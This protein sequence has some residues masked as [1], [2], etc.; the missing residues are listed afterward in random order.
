MLPGE[1]S[2]RYLLLLLLLTLFWL[3]LTARAT[4]T[5]T[6]Q[7]FWYDNS[8]VFDL[9]VKALNDRFRM[10]GLQRPGPDGKT[11]RPDGL[12]MAISREWEVV[13]EEDID[14]EDAAGRCA[15]LL[16]LRRVA[17]T[18]PLPLDESGSSSS[19]SSGSSGEDGSSSSRSESASA[20]SDGPREILVANVHL[21]F[22][23][24]DAS[25]RIRVREVH[26]LLTHLDQ[27]KSTLAQAP[28]ALI[29]GDFNG[30][31][32]S[33]VVKFLKRY[34]WQCTYSLHNAQK[35]DGDHGALWQNGD[36]AA[37]AGGGGGGGAEEVNAEEEARWISHFTHQKRTVGVDYIWMLN[38]SHPR[39]PVPDWTDFVFSEM[40][41][42]LARCGF[43]RPADA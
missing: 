39:A 33:R 35:A 25:G 43:S 12:F 26:K 32:G 9:Y 14:F 4:T 19:S 41:Q 16:H 37:R 10:H 5:A 22:P 3:L 38:P 21:L 23:H 34:G 15:Q 27:Y 40:A 24:D 36:P 7:E 30:E 18:K 20:F 42:Q 31:V 6:A 29:C 8:E 2:C 11:P 13:W 17:P 28:P 1:A